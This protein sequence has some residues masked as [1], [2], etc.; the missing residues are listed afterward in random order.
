M[1]YDVFNGMLN[2]TQLINQPGTKQKLVY[3]MALM[4]VLLSDALI[5][6]YL[7]SVILVI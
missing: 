4:F 6:Q 2:P 7:L 1:T 5:I 3:P